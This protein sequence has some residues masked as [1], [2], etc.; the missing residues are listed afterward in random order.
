HELNELPVKVI[1][2]RQVYLKDVAYAEDASMIQ[3]ALVRINGKPQVYVPIYR[4]QGAS[5]LAVVN[6]VK[7]ELPL[8]KER[9]PAGVE[10]DLVMD[11]SVYIGNAIQ[12]LVHEGVVGALLAAGMILFFLGDFRSTFIAGLSIPLAVLAAIAALLAL[13]KTIN[14]M[15][16]G[17]LALA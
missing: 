14:V 8:M 1:D 11:Q 9:A 16:L 7:Q 10:L 13:D 4:Q 5:S 15:T 17:G 3:T 12:S 6:S 2:D